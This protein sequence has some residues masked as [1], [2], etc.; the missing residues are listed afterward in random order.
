[1]TTKTILVSRALYILSLAQNEELEFNIVGDFEVW[2]EAQY[3]VIL[4]MT[5][6]CQVDARI[7]CK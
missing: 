7:M 1:M 6:L 4:G 5:W 3:G 2:S